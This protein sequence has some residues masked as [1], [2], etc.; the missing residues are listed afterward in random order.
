MSDKTEMPAEPKSHA[1]QAVKAWS[2][3]TREL[4]PAPDA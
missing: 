2:S 4:Q 3:R 1:V